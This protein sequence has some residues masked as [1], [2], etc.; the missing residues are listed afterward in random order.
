[1]NVILG[2]TWIAGEFFSPESASCA[3]SYSVSFPP[4]VTAVA[5]K[6]PR[7]FCQKCSWQVA[8]KY[9]Y[10]LDPPKSEWADYASVRAECGNLSGNEL[11]RNSSEALWTDPGVK[12]GTSVRQLISTSKRKRR[13]GT[14]GRTFSQIL[15]SE[16]KATV[17]EVCRCEPH[18]SRFTY[19][20]QSAV[21]RSTLFP[22]H[23]RCQSHF[24]L[25]TCVADVKLFESLQTALTPTV[26]HTELSSGSRVSRAGNSLTS[27]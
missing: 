2:G 27:H 25:F 17:S 4:R 19:S 5:R 8:P 3:D 13:R 24:T 12:S 1:M 15:A 22:F 23:T 16:E 10:T 11:T 20:L 21:R 6:R 18:L 9:A 26:E 14:N 7:S